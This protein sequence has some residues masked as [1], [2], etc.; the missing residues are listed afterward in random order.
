[1]AGSILHRADFECHWGVPIPYSSFI[2]HARNVPS[3]I[4]AAN[5]DEGEETV[6]LAPRIVFSSFSHAAGLRCGEWSC[7][8]TTRVARRSEGDTLERYEWG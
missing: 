7:E 6:G 3:R 8:A 1:M 4:S 2:S 5:T